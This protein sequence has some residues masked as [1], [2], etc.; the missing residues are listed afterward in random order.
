MML[1]LIL[2][3]LWIKRI[4]FFDPIHYLVSQEQTKLKIIDK[5]WNLS[6]LKYTRLQMTQGSY[7]EVQKQ[8][9]ALKFNM[10]YNSKM[11]FLEFISICFKV[12]L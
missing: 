6:R 2:L 11:E 10:Q 7:D 5:R 4:V 3:L 1:Q 9:I 12:E 8:F